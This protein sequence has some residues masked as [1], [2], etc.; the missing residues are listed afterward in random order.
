S[1]DIRA[2]RL[3]GTLTG[4]ALWGYVRLEEEKPDYTFGSPRDVFIFLESLDR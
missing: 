1:A 4:L 3:A 2:G